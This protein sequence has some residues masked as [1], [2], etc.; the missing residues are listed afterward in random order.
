[1]FVCSMEAQSRVS[2]LRGEVRGSFPADAQ[3]EMSPCS[4]GGQP[5]MSMVSSTGSFEV[6]NLSA[7]CYRV[8]VVAQ[9]SGK[10]LHESLMDI[11]PG[12]GSL[13]LRTRETP[14]PAR[15]LTGVVNAKVVRVPAPKKA[16][17]AFREAVRASVEGD[18]ERA[19]V[20]LKEAIRMHPAFFEAHA[21]LGTQYARL[22]RQEEALTEFEEARRLDD[23]SA[24]IWTNCAASYLEV[25]R[26]AD[27]EAAL[28][29]AVRRDPAYPQAHYLLGHVA[30]LKRDY[31]EA[32]RQMAMV[33]DQLPAAKRALERIDA[34]SRA[35]AQ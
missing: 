7:G 21:N 9:S 14:A 3:V 28:R 35:L 34:R 10:R 31:A 27:A 6:R 2:V 32:R 30:A 25:K 26:V 29:E 23:S 1:M 17:T 5:E 33:A 19:I 24:L 22:G 11:G 8:T 4:G 16:R 20:K 15:P 12:T 18:R 13:E